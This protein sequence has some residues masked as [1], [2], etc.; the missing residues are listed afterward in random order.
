MIKFLK[1]TSAV[2]LALI[3]CAGGA[4]GIN[5]IINDRVFV[6]SYTFAHEEVPEG[7]DGFKI[8]Q[9][10]DFHEAPFL[11]QIAQKVK[12]TAPDIMVI[13]GDSVQL[14]RSEADEILK[15]AKE[16]PDI[17]VYVISGNHETQSGKYEELMEAYKESG[18]IPID[19]DS[20]EIKRGEESILLVGVK[21]PEHNEPTEGK[22]SYMRD[23][24]REEFPD[25]PCFSILLMHR[26]DL[27]PE[28]WETPADLILS[29]HLHGGIIRIPFMGGVMGK[30][31]KG[32]FP[33][34]DKGLFT[35]GESSMI[36]SAGC[37]KNPDKKR[38]FNPP[39][40]AIIT[41]ERKLK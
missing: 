32:F 1:I 29:G 27:F 12:K 28:V 21:D 11:E 39:E 16:I 20:V 26:A 40:V 3:I 10:S 19:Y 36:V 25:G 8:L 41:L 31:G 4:L 33:E 2:L 37:D 22:L 9:L 14:P 13:T 18:L 24:I 5:E 38:Y 34:Y 15:L 30:R 17:P 7:F 23:K 6:S 35:H